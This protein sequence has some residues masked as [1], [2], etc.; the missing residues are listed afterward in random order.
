[1]AQ[2]TGTTDSYDIGTAQG[3]REDLSDTI[4]DLFPADTWAVSTLDREKASNTYTEWLGQELAGAT[5]NRQIEGDDASFA[6]LSA[7]ARYGSYTQILS[8]TFLVSDS[9]EATNRAG[10][11][12]EAA[13]GLMVRMREI[14][15]DLEQ[16][17]T[18][19]QIS[20]VGGSG[21]GRSTAGMESW[22]G[23][24]TSSNGTTAANAVAA[25]TTAATATTAPVTSGTAGTAP[26]DGTTF[27]AL[28]ANA[29]NLALEGAWI[30][31]GDPRVILMSSTQ[32]KVADTFTGIATRFVD[33][34]KGAQASI[35]GAA[36]SYVSDFGNHTLMLHRYMRTSVVLCLDPD[37]WAVRYLRPFTKR[38]LAKTGDGTKHQIIG[39]ACLVARNWRASSKVVALA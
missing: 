1:L 10:R 31:G 29:L 19:N 5:A 34:N 22:I 24:P 15:R 11:G 27:G 36:S 14:K 30:Q 38:E 26:T 16:A 17:L 13:R 9:L 2:L 4:F 25:T 7:P 33:V 23:G 35:I 8:K 32:K 37:Y 3:M 20:T 6:T 18:Q 39:E 12:R 21:T 28:T